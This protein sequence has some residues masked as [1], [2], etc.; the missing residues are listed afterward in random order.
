MVGE[1]G[2]QDCNVP[3][4]LGWSLNVEPASLGKSLHIGGLHLWDGLSVQVMH[5]GGCWAAHSCLV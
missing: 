1:A 5:L 4:Y 3:A 2:C